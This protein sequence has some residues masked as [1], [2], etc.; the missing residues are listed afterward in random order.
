MPNFFK[1]I[2]NDLKQ[3]KN[4]EAYLFVL[5]AIII[6]IFD[7]F[8]LAKPNWITSIT[9][10]ILAMLVLGRLEDRRIIEQLHKHLN[11][12]GN[13]TFLDKY[14]DSFEEDIKNAKELWIIGVSL[15]RTITNY[16]TLFRSKLC[17]GDKIRVLLAKPES[18]LSAMTTRRDRRNIFPGTFDQIINASLEQFCALSRMAHAD[19]EI[20]VSTVTYSFGYFAMDIDSPDGVIYLEHYGYKIDEGDVPKLILHPDDGNWYEI[21]HKELL[22]LWSDSEIWECRG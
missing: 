13:V 17:H 1:Q 3:W 19:I 2:L 10:V 20:R 11:S 16:Y 14:P 4:I 8:E 7:L 22:T 5:L 21:F 18:V 9:L 15:N 6:A 12:S